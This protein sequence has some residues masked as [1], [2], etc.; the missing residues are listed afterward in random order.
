MGFW[1]DIPAHLNQ[2]EFAEFIIQTLAE[3]DI[4]WV[5]EVRVQDRPRPVGVVLGKFFNNGERVVEPHVEWFPWASVRNKL[6]C[7]AEFMR[8]VG[9][10]Y[11]VLV[12]AGDTDVPLFEKLQQYRILKKGCKI[13]GYFASDKDAQLFYTPG[14]D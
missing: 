6:E 8:Q 11:K 9:K 4:E 12:F 5:L 1:P 2:D 13:K 14:P 7:G 10:K 3:F